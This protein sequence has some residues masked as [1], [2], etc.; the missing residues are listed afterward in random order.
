[1]FTPGQPY[2]GSMSTTGENDELLPEQPRA[3]A[4]AASRNMTVSRQL[5][6]PLGVFHNYC[7]CA[8]CLDK[9]KHGWG[10]HQ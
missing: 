6:K 7:L 8:E 1:M 5:F 4:S 10:W 9:D 3:N 2:K